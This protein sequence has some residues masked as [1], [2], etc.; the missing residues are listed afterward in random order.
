MLILRCKIGVLTLL[1]VL[2]KR[3]DPTSTAEA[4]S[5]LGVRYGAQDELMSRKLS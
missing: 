4:G 3:K 1:A 5:R 2:L